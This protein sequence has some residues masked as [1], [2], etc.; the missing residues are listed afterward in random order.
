MVRLVRSDRWFLQGGVPAAT[1]SATTYEGSY[2]RVYTVEEQGSA[3]VA[4]DERCT[5]HSYAQ[6]NTTTHVVNVLAGRSLYGASCAAANGTNLAKAEGWWHDANNPAN[7][8]FSGNPANQTVTRGLPTEHHVLAGGGVTLVTKTA[9]PISSIDGRGTVTTVGLDAS[10]G[11][12]RTV[13]VAGPVSLVTETEMDPGRGVPV[14]S[15]D[16]NGNQARTCWDNLGR[17]SMVLRADGSN[18]KPGTVPV[19]GLD[20]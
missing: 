19:C 18:T 17:V 2:G 20:Q 10:F 4:G 11:Y 15:V 8:A 7:P 6:P 16:A 13:T 3:Q 9:R 1:R 5:Y 14:R 12:P